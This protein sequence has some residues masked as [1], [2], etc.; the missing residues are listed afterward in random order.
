MSTI[1]IV[2]KDLPKGKG[3]TVQTDAGAPCV[4]QSRSPA[5]SMAMDILRQLHRQAA[6]IQYGQATATLAGELV[7]NQ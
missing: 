7:Q 3:V 1:T 4:G 2:L 6:D 5:D